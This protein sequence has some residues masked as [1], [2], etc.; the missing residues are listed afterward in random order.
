MNAPAAVL[1][2]Q[3]AT[4]V[5]T[6]FARCSTARLTV[7][8]TRRSSNPLKNR[9]LR[10]I[11]TGKEPFWQGG[12]VVAAEEQPFQAEETRKDRLVN[13]ASPRACRR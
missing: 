12:Q 11:E 3:I 9:R 1:F 8:R 7:V 5:D 10:V 13:A 2:L 4:E 6:R